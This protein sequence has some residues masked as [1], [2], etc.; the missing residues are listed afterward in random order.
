MPDQ[1]GRPAVEPRRYLEIGVLEEHPKKSG[2]VVG[3][4]EGAIAGGLIAGPLGAGVGA[5]A[6]AFIGTGVGAAGEYT[7][8]KSELIVGAGV[9]GALCIGGAAIGGAVAKNAVLEVAKKT[10]EGVTEEVVK[11]GA[12][13]ALKWAVGG[14]V[15]AGVGAV[16]VSGAPFVSLIYQL[17]QSNHRNEELERENRELR[18]RALAGGGDPRVPA[19]GPV[20]A[21]PNPDHPVPVPAGGAGGPRLFDA[22]A[23]EAEERRRRVALE[24]KM[25]RFKCTIS[26]RIMDDPVLANDGYNYEKTV[27]A[28]LLAAASTSGAPYRSTKKPDTILTNYLPNSDLRESIEEFLEDHPDMRVDHHPVPAPAV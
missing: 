2:A 13:A 11:K 25:D 26:G 9:V 20:A 6:G 23:R 27:L 21:A 3:A 14:A 15:A 10:A 8:Y 1:I 7:G 16:V 5:I 28:A 17:V 4:V 12:E 22:G 18:L 24:R 19:E